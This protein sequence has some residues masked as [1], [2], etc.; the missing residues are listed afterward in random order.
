M[1]YLTPNHPAVEAAKASTP[2]V[3][4]PLRSPDRDQQPK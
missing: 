3:L 2:P 1:T 4:D